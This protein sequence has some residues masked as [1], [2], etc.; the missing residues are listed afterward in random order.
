MRVVFVSLGPQCPREKQVVSGKA[1]ALRAAGLG[2]I[3]AFTDEG[4]M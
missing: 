3:P 2:L 4:G 1:P